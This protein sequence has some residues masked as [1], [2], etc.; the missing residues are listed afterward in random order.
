MVDD[1][2]KVEREVNVEAILSEYGGGLLEFILMES[3]VDVTL[4]KWYTLTDEDINGRTFSLAYQMNLLHAHLNEL[5][6]GVLFEYFIQRPISQDEKNQVDQVWSLRK[7][8]LSP[9]V[10]DYNK[11]I[12]RR[13]GKEIVCLNALYTLHPKEWLDNKVINVYTKALIQYFDVQHR[14][15][16]VKEKMMLAGA[17]SCQYIGR[18]LS[19]W[20]RIM[21]SPAGVKLKKKSIWEQ[22]TSM[23]WDS[24]VSNYFHR[25]YLKVVIQN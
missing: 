3:E 4:K 12:Y 21:S 19:V 25:G 10:M 8:E 18:A 14:A 7:D 2:V 16:P 1:D 17:Y 5:L 13:I 20:T 9:E 6:T 11:S 15:R 23:Q 24:T 22:I